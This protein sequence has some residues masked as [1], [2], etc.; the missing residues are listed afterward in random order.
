VSTLEF[1][2]DQ[3]QQ[4]FLHS[5]EQ[6]TAELELESLPYPL[7][8]LEITESLMMQQ[9]SNIANLLQTLRG[10]G[11]K[12]SVDDFGTGYSSLSYLVNFPVDQIKIDKAFVEKL[13]AGP[14]HRA[15]VEAIVGL[16]RSLEL[17]VTAEGVET[18][19][20]L[21]IITAYQIEM[22]QGY[23]FYR[24]MPKQAFLSLIHEQAGYGLI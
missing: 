9:H 21:D 22:I 13:T 18:K 10:R 20:Q 19:E 7:L 23:Y 17:S 16:S 5:F 4:R 3:L 24:P 6:I 11:I 2:S 14:R 1:W 8:T 15:I 12:I